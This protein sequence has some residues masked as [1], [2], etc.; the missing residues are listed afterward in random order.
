MK[1]LLKVVL[2]F[3]ALATATMPDALACAV[4]FG[5]SDSPLSKGMNFGILALLGVVAPVLFGVAA[6]AWNMNKRSR[7][8]AQGE[9]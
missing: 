7:A 6:F 4:C 2:V 3:A 5:A 1:H 8:L 9:K